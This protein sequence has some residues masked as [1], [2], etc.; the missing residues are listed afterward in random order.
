M[1]Q[2]RLKSWGIVDGELGEEGTGRIL[3]GLR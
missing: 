1:S 3:P 2:I